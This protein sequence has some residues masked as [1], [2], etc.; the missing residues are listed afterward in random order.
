[1]TWRREAIF[2]GHSRVNNEDLLTNADLQAANRG[3]V[4]SY[5]V[6]RVFSGTPRR[7]FLAHQIEWASDRL[8][9]I[10]TGRER[11]SAYAADGTLIQE[12]ALGEHRWAV[13]PDGHRGHHF[14]S[15]H[16][17]GDRVWVVAHNYDHPS[18][19][20]E[21]TWPDLELV[22]VHATGAAWAH[23]TWDGE[24]G[25]ITCDSRFGSLH[26][27]HSGETI[28]T[29]DEDNVITRGLAVGSDHLFI[30]RS[31]F[32][33]RGERLVNAGGLWIVDR[34][35]LT[36][37]ER[38]RF[39]G[40][41]C[42]NEIRLLDSPDECHNGEPFNEELLAG[43]SRP[44][45]NE[46]LERQRS[47]LDP[48]HASASWRV[49]A[50]LRATKHGIQRLQPARRGSAIPARNQSLLTGWSVNQVWG[51]ALA[52]CAVI[53][54]TDAVLSHVILITLLA[55]GPFCGLLTGRWTRTATAGIW[56]LALA[57][58]LGIP[59]EIWDTRTQFDDL[60]VVTAVALL[61]TV[62]ATLVERRR[63]QQIR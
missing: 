23:N 15:V 53:A 48:V 17:S 36:T 21:L 33:G 13:S 46:N 51:V 50:P 16:R 8:L 28:W 45:R 25:L 2:V 58:L 30:G 9:V 12:V 7:L 63:Y 6:D 40:I 59:D 60:G 56:A 20:W 49:T 52:L 32:G 27:V 3:D 55:A 37:V 57:V 38:L 41:G 14:N 18:E 22:E 26:E 11:L 34:S 19:L 54:A 24:L 1:L 35:T 5:A 29:A 44:G 42:V 61:S 62:A 31:E 4:T 47:W 39:P 10:D 43:L